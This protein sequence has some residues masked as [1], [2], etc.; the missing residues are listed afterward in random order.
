MS[1]THMLSHCSDLSNFTYFKVNTRILSN[2]HTSVF[3]SHFKVKL[4]YKA[5]FKITKID[6]FCTNETAII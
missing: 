3:L 6:K 5:H 2:F 1:L 4:S